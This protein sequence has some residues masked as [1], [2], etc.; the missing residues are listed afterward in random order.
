MACVCYL[1]LFCNCQRPMSPGRT[2][3]GMSGGSPRK[4]AELPR[5]GVGEYGANHVHVVR[6][7]ATSRH[8]RSR[9]TLFMSR[10]SPGTQEPLAHL[11]TP[12]PDGRSRKRVR[13]N[14]D[15]MMEGDEQGDSEES[16]YDSKVG[17]FVHSCQHSSIT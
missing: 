13:W 14:S 16:S 5:Q 12:E 17:S 6:R 7:V 8:P 10:T 1:F 9:P 4:S 2:Q 3:V 15:S 11:D